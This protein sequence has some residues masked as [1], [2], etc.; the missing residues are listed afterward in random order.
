MGLGEDDFG[1]VEAVD[2]LGEAVVVGVTKRSDRRSGADLGEPFGV[3]HADI[4]DPESLWVMTPAS[5]LVGRLHT[6]MFNAS[7]TRSVI[8]DDAARQ[9]TMNREQ[10]SMM[11]A[12]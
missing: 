7:M 5:R 10:T 11:N 12:T 2:A 8:I 4:C 1:R 3:S 9:P 6:A